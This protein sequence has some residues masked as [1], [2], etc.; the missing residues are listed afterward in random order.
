MINTNPTNSLHEK[1]SNKVSVSIICFTYNHENYISQTIESF[2][3]QIINFKFEIILHDDASTDGTAVIVREYERKFPN[4]FTCIFQ[5]ENQ[6]IKC[7]NAM[8]GLTL[9]KARGKYIALCEGDDFWTDPLKLQQQVD[10][11]ET[12]PTFSMSFHPSMKL[13]LETNI[14]S[15]KPLLGP[16]KIQS[17]YNLDDLLRESNF[18]PTSSVVFRGWEG[19]NHL[20]AWFDQVKIGDFHCSSLLQKKGTLVL[21]TKQ[22]LYIEFIPEVS[23]PRRNTFEKANIILDIYRLFRSEIDLKHR[24]SFSIGISNY[25]R[26]V[27]NEGLKN[28]LKLKPFFYLMMAIYYSI[29]FNFFNLV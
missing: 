9:N 23:G 20:P 27:A 26:H 24:K 22:C 12:N 8:I 13:Y 11:L 15:E 16:S 28:G 29:P 19:P 3:S 18:I 6:Y 5:K 10:F 7:P 4:L 25:Y 21:S 1:D 2:L 17:T 14:T